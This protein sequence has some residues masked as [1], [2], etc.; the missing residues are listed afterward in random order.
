MNDP[1]KMQNLVYDWVDF[2]KLSK[3]KKI[4]GKSGDFAPNLAQN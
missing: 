4:W 3:F 2:S 1:D